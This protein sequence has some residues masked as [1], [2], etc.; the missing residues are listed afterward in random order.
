[1][2]REALSMAAMRDFCSNFS[3]LLDA[4]PE[5]EAAT[6]WLYFHDGKAIRDIA[7]MS[8]ASSREVVH[9]LVS[10][11]DRLNAVVNSDRTWEDME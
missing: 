4:L 2:E 6:I 10:G 9:R 5:E 7:T 1:M 11:M 3:D 8:E